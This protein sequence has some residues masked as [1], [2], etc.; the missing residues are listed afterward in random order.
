MKLKMRRIY[1][2]AVESD[3]GFNSMYEIMLSGNSHDRRK[4]Y[5]ALLR[6]YPEAHIKREAMGT[7]KIIDGKRVW[8]EDANE[9]TSRVLLTFI[10]EKEIPY[11]RLRCI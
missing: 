10:T 4:Q 6:K 8:V 3:N 2:R 7:N 9:V 1:S 11:N 5:K